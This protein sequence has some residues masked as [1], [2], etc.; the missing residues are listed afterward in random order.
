LE[1]V[2]DWMD[3][4]K[5]AKLVPYYSDDAFQE[6]IAA[7]LE[8]HAITTERSADADAEGAF[9]TR[10]KW[11]LPAALFHFSLADRDQRL[12]LEQ[13]EA[14]QIAKL[15]SEPSPPLY[16]S[17][18]GCTAVVDLPCALGGNDLLGL[19]SRRRTVRAAGAPSITLSQLSDC[20]FAGLGIIGETKNAATSLP[21]S[22]APSG[23]ARHPYEAYVW[24]R[25]VEG[26]APGVYH[27]SG[28]DHA[29][30]LVG[31]GEGPPLSMLVNGQE[32]ADEMPCLICLVALL[33]RS[34]WKYQDPN[35]YRVCLIEAGHIG[36]NVMLAATAH[37]LSA[38]PTAA[39]DQRL[40]RESIG[41]SDEWTHAPVYAL[42]L[43]QPPA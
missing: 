19:M 13:N 23:G 15:S 18:D 43:A 10:W 29:L 31:D 35:A 25:N 32:W 2:D 24:A 17:N 26:L 30:G 12:S 34:M 42:T 38:C 9:E 6:V 39:L 5:V 3:V 14:L 8:N 11:G 7:L 36:Q 40:I 21:L 16:T 27:Y 28:R 37:G 41:D 4:D 22:M 20:L 1:L 33:E